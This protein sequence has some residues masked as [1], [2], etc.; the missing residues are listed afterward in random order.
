MNS[1]RI[2][3][4][5]ETTGYPDSITIYAALLTVWNECVQEQSLNSVSSNT[6]ASWAERNDWVYNFANNK[7]QQFEDS[8]MKLNTEELAEL[9]IKDQCKSWKI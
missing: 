2:K 1:K 4:I 6:L 9:C 7:W 8:D 3:E 5:Q